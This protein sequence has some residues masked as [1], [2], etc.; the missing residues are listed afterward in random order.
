M[1]H[2]TIQIIASSDEDL[3]SQLKYS[4]RE[5]GSTGAFTDGLPASA[6]TYE[7]KAYLP[8][9]QNYEAAET[10]P[11][12]TL[13]I[14]KID[15]LLKAPAPALPVYDGDAYA[16][17]TAGKVQNN[18]VIEYAREKSGPYTADI[19]TGINAG[20]Y[21]VWYR[22]TADT[23]NYNVVPETEVLGVK[24]LRKKIT[25]TVTP[26][27]SSYVYDGS[28]HEPQITVKEGI[29]EIG[30][31]QYDI[32][33]SGA[34]GQ[35]AADLLRAAGVYTANIEGKATGNYEFTATATV[36]IIAADQNA[37]TITGKPSHVY[38]GDTITTLDTTGGTAN[39][40]VKWSITKG[41]TSAT[42]DPDTGKL[43]IRDIG[44]VTVTA[45]RTVLNYGTVSADWT[46]DVEPKPVVAEVTIQPK[47]YDGSDSISSNYIHAIVKSSDRVNPADTLQSAA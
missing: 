3:R 35:A 41:N 13:T 31:D 5:S 22:V 44:S 34:S 10:S 42:I 40:T 25:P 20:D 18:V 23:N 37:L 36:E 14:K 4:Y 32:T 7:V 15:A 16:L 46:F 47:V 2:I 6:S 43:T 27:E 21:T 33:W 28:K 29:T 8:A 45:E 12:L 17:V 39:G 11:C 38:Y 26:A 9:S 30:K 1:P 24:I 19:P